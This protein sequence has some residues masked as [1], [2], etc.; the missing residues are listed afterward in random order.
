MKMKRRLFVLAALLFPTAAT[1]LPRGGVS[2]PA[3]PSTNV[4]EWADASDV[5]WADGS[6]VLWS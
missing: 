5:E 3:P 1:A 4:V 6:Q 2:G